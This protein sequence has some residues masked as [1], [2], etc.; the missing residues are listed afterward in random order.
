MKSETLKGILRSASSVR[1]EVNGL[2]TK[3]PLLSSHEHLRCGLTRSRDT[4]L[5]PVLGADCG[6]VLCRDADTSPPESSPRLKG[7]E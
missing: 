4:V 2:S 7:L 6:S 5:H 1:P 3:E